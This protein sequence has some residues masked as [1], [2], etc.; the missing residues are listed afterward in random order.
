MG[1]V[2]ALREQY[3]SESANPDRFTSEH[4]LVAPMDNNPNPNQ[5][6]W[7][8]TLSGI[9]IINLQGTTPASWTREHWNLVLDVTIDR[10][11]GQ[12][13][14]RAAQEN[15]LIF[16][17][18]RWAP[19]VTPNAIYDAQQSVDAGFAV[20][21]FALRLDPTFDVLSGQTYQMLDG[22][23]F[24]LAVRDSDAVLLRVGYTMNMYGRIIEVRTPPIG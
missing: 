4:W 24:S 6:K 15:Y 7:L 18:E 20:D 12:A 23:Q 9:A 22:V 17:P 2:Q 1:Q 21:D 13:G 8:W 5:Q 11:F 3:L 19:L 14:R 10:A 16:Q